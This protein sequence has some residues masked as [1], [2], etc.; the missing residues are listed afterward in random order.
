MTMRMTM[1]E[2]VHGLD[3]KQASAEITRLRKQCEERWER[4]NE[5]SCDVS[6]AMTRNMQLESALR[7]A[8]KFV[9]DMSGTCPYDMFDFRAKD[10]EAECDDSYAEC[11]R[12]YFEK[13]DDSR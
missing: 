8:C 4:C 6:N 1:H 7:M 13:G 9:A 2:F 12:R 11:W 3:C 10:C 5:L